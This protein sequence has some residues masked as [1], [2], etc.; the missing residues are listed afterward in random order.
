MARP[1]TYYTLLMRD[2]P[3]EPWRIEFGD[4]DLETVRDERDERRYNGHRTFDI[5]IVKTDGT[6]NAINHKVDVLNTR[7]M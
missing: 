2:N 7:N 3:N 5:K 4:W 1:R 6:Q